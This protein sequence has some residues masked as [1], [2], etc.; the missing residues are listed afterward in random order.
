MSK[1]SR[2]TGNYRTRAATLGVGVYRCPGEIAG[3]KGRKNE[4][5]APII[6]IHAQKCIAISARGLR[7]EFEQYLST[8]SGSYSHTCSPPHSEANN[9]THSSWQR[10]I[11]DTSQ[12]GNLLRERGRRVACHVFLEKVVVAA[13][14]IALHTLGGICQVLVCG[15][16]QGCQYFF[17]A[18][19]EQSYNVGMLLIP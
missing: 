2:S 3:K 10:W 8:L 11:Y 13:E 5:T 19:A 12:F 6:Y 4:P 9:Y 7:I 14:A 15:E 17:G 1:S 16:D 18:P